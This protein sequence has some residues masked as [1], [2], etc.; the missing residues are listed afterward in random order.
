[1]PIAQFFS[2]RFAPVLFLDFDGVL[3]PAGV[4]TI[5]SDGEFVPHERLFAWRNNLEMELR[6]HPSLEII[7][8]SDW[9]KYHAE[10]DLAAFLGKDLGRRVAGVMPYFEQGSRAEAIRAEASRRGFRHW[11]ALDDHHSVHEACD[12]GDTR[13]VACHPDTGIGCHKARNELARR[14]AWVSW[15]A[16]QNSLPFEPTDS[17]HLP[18]YQANTFSLSA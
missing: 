11:L 12:Q 10:E 8:S 18:V 4:P 5:N 15:L 13:F 7:I 17:T 16:R 9:R 2:R 14:L 6:A 1:M 3:H